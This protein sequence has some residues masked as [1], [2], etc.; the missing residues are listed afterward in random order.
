MSPTEMKPPAEWPAEP[1]AIIISI[2]F[3]RG[4][5]NERDIYPHRS[6][7]TYRSI[8]PSC[9]RRRLPITN[10]TEGQGMSQGPSSSL[11]QRMS[12]SSSTLGQGLT[13]VT[14]NDIP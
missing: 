1:E 4:S 7:H 2:D 8:L 9:D 11:E 5:S 10:S 12:A 14:L 6:T 13:T 3:Q